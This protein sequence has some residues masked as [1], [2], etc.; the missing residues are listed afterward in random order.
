MDGKEMP[1]S[2]DVNGGGAG[3]LRC[4]AN[5]SGPAQ[6]GGMIRRPHNIFIAA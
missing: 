3:P 1:E 6:A 2:A 4:F 5:R